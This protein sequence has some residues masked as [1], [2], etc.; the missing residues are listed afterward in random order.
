MWSVIPVVLFSLMASASPVD[1]RKALT[2]RDACDGVDAMPI[3]YHEYR[4]DKCKPKY[5]ISDDGV[6]RQCNFQENSCVA[7][8]QVRT[9]F[10]YGQEQ[11]FPNTFC[12]G[13][14]TCTITS[15]HTRTVGWSVNISPKVEAALKVGVSGSYTKSTAD[16]VARSFSIKLD[17]KKCGYFTFVPVIKSTWYVFVSSIFPLHRLSLYAIR[18]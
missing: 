17:N 18:N 10:F 13:P 7:F 8:C 5:K 2:R 3:L 6:C 14:Q 11:P 16:A 9:N 1:H 12:H 4:S 15:T